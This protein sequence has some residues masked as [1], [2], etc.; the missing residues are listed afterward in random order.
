MQHETMI[1]D[2]DEEVQGYSGPSVGTMLGF[3][4]LNYVGGVV[5]HHGGHVAQQAKAAL[6]QKS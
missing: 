1:I 3:A 2:Q 4:V 6:P 5:G